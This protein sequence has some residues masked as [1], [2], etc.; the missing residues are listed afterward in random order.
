MAGY[1]FLTN[2]DAIRNLE[3]LNGEHLTSALH[4][5]MR[6]KI[7]YGDF[8]DFYATIPEPHCLDIENILKVF[9]TMH[10]PHVNKYRI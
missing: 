9:K 2:G 10:T 3:S 8:V 4:A 6:D 5:A 1:I 7:P